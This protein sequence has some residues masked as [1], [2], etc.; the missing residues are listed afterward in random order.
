VQSKFILWLTVALI[1]L[2]GL[3]EAATFYFDVAGPDRV[4][5]ESWRWGFALLLAF[6]IDADSRDRAAIY[7]PS[8][9]YGLFVAMIWPLYVPY[10]LVRT[11][12]RMGWLW[13]LGLI[14]LL[15]LGVLLQILLIGVF[16]P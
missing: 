8:L 6:W 3:Y 4:F 14:A 5:Y 15:N 13:L 2:V 12:A 10:Y 11:R 1:V 7:R 16:S 9:D